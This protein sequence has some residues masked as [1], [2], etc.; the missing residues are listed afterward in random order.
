M[1]DYTNSLHVFSLSSK[2]TSAKENKNVYDAF[3]Q[4]GKL[5]VQ[6]QVILNPQDASAQRKGNM[7]LDKNSSKLKKEKGVKCCGSN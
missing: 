1:I 2:H 4:L 5:A 7:S 6:R 3:T